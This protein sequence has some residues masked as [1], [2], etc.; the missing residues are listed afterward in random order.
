MFQLI[1]DHEDVY[2]AACRIE[3]DLIN[4]MK[5]CL[6][7]AE[8]E[9]FF[10]KFGY[11]IRS[12]DVIDYDEPKPLTFEQFVVVHEG[13][14]GRTLYSSY[15]DASDAIVNSISSESNLSDLITDLLQFYVVS[16]NRRW[17][18]ENPKSVSTAQVAEV[19]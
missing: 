16:R 18:A 19:R 17:S 8:I 6:R 4:E 5:A 11:E 2:A 7:E 14:E 12:I 9:E 13:Q 10:A 1:Q 3:L 15:S